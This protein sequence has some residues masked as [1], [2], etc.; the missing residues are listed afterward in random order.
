MRLKTIGHF[1]EHPLYSLSAFSADTVVRLA[2]N[3]D[4]SFNKTE[5]GDVTDDAPQD[6]RLT[7]DGHYAVVT[8]PGD[9]FTEEKTTVYEVLP[10]HEPET[11]P[12]RRPRLSDAE[13]L[14][15]I[16]EHLRGESIASVQQRHGLGHSTLPAWMNAFGIAPRS[17]AEERRIAALE[18]DNARLTEKVS[19]LE[20]AVD[21][22]RRENNR[23]L[24]KIRSARLALVLVEKAA[25]TLPDEEPGNENAAA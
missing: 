12:A 1:G 11:T 14:A 2:Q 23:L 6:I 17:N 22:L 21:S 13:K 19:S 3:G 7:A 20:T 15:I 25:D 4:S 24:T 10:E 5:N 16:A 9:F 8:V 18:R